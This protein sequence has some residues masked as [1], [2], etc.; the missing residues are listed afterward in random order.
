MI[1]ST[2]ISIIVKIGYPGIFVLMLLEGMLLPIPSEVVMAFGGYLVVTGALQAQL[3]IPAVILL[4]LSGTAGNVAGASIAYYIGKLGG[5]RFIER[6]GRYLL[7]DNRSVMRAQRFFDKYG[8]VSVFAT[9]LVP[10]F[11]TFISIP[12]GVAQMDIRSFLVYT[13]LG[14]LGW[15]SILIYLGFTL[16]RKWQLLLPFFDVLTY[17]VALLI[18]AIFIWW[19]CTAIRRKFGASTER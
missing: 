6:Y 3:G 17:A 7:I 8:S 4:L 10:I 13:S 9:R 11:R 1:I 12:A 18:A 2:T 19:L 16:G 5:L 15:N 14:T